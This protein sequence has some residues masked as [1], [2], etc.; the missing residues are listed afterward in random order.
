MVSKKNYLLVS[1][2][3][4]KANSFRSFDGLCLESFYSLIRI[5]FGQGSIRSPLIKFDNIF[6]N[7]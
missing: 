5:W 6:G 2:I 7:Y 1:L 4:I 3:Y